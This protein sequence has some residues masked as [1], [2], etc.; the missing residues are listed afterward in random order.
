MVILPPG[1]RHL[2]H[3]TGSSCNTAGEL[4][5]EMTIILCVADSDDSSMKGR[6][7]VLFQDYKPNRNR[8]ANVAFFVS[9]DTFSIQG[10]LCENDLAGKIF[11]EQLKSPLF[12]IPSGI[13]ETLRK[14]GFTD[15]DS[16]LCGSR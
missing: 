8:L 2:L 14:S 4:V 15:M 11:V 7:Y 3:T 10:P 6:V 5:S 16:L 12:N 9:P 1:H 13:K